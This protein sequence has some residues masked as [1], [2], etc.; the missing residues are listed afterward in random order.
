MRA[1]HRF[2]ASIATLASLLLF[3][4]LALPAG[5]FAQSEGGT[6]AGDASAVPVQP[7]GTLPGE[8]S[9][10]LVQVAGGLVDPVNVAAD[11]SGRL[12]IVE[13]I[14]RI[15]IVDADGTLLEEPYLDISGRVKTDFLEQGLLGLAFAPDYDES[16]HF[17]VYYTDYSTNGDQ[18]IV[19]YSVSED[20]PDVADPESARL[21]LDIGFD[22]YF[23]HNGGNLVFGPDGYLYWSTGDGGSAGDPYD[24][25]QDIRDLYGI[26][27]RIDVSVR[28]SGRAYGIPEDNPFARSSR[29]QLAPAEPAFYHPGARAEIWAYGLRNPWQFS[30]DGETGELYIADVGQNEWEEINVEP[31]DSSGGLNYGWDLLEAS[32]CYP[33]SIEECPRSQVGV[34]PVAEYSHEDGDCSI[35]GLGVHRGEGSASLDGVYFASDYCSGRVWGLARDGEGVWAFEQLLDTALLASGGGNDAQGNVYLTSCGC[36]FGRDY[37]PFADPSGAV[38]QVVAVD[39]VP[40][41]AVTAPLEDE[42]A[43]NDG[44]EMSEETTPDP[45]PTDEAEPELTAGAGPT[46][47]LDATEAPSPDATAPA[48]PEASPSE[49]D[50]EDEVVELQLRAED[51]S[52]DQESLTVPAGAMVELTLINE[53]MAQHNLALYESDAA[54]ELLFEGEIFGGPGEERVYEFQ[55]PSEPGEYYFRCEVHP[56]Q[57]NGVFIVE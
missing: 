42:N 33:A 15:R 1:I 46:A 27:G 43:G 21:I 56:G 9:I 7:G 49:L 44:A 32:H 28:E 17:Y 8:P 35:T 39:E 23:N 52:F 57:M 5:A 10:A 54:E 40:D 11:G 37:D 14:G 36:S 3:A 4:L 22:P 34:L 2:P 29:V 41:D 50:G 55:A 38:W 30:F 16:G 24:N 26:I 45:D 48:S 13:R 20:D 25:A 6:S 12:F 51:I 19:R 53:D 47:T 18:R 31:A